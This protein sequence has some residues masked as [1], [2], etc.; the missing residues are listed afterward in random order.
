MEDPM[1]RGLIWTLLCTLLGGFAHADGPPPLIRESTGPAR[2]VSY[3]EFVSVREYA[4]LGDAISHERFL[5]IPPGTWIVDNPIVLSRDEPLY[6][7]GGDRSNTRIV[8]SDPT[9]PLFELERAPLV[10]IAGVQLEPV[11]REAPTDA[12]LIVAYNDAPT[13]LEIVD[14]RLTVGAIELLGPG[15][16]RLQNT[17]IRPRGLVTNPILLDH[18]DGRLTVLGGDISNQNKEPRVETQSAFHIRVRRGRVRIYGLSTE[19][20]IGPADFRIDS[21]SAHGPH[22]LTAVRSEGNN[23]ANS[24]AYRSTMVSVPSSSERIDLVIKSSIGAWGALGYGNGRLVEYGAAGRVWLLGNNVRTGAK[25]LVEGTGSE[26]TLV[27]IGNFAFSNQGILPVPGASRIRGG[28][29]Y[30]HMLR[31]LSRLEPADQDGKRRVKRDKPSYRFVAAEPRLPTGVPALPDDE[32]PAPL[33]RPVLRRPLDG[34]LSAADFGA[35][36][37]GLHDDTAALQALLDAQCGP[38]GSLVFIPQGRYRITRALHYNTAYS[39]KHGTGGWIVGAG[40]NKT[41][42]ERSPETPG[43][44]FVTRSMSGVTIQGLTFRTTAW[45]ADEP[46]AIKVPAFSLGGSPGNLPATHFVSFDDVRF[47]GGKYGLGVRLIHSGGNGE[48]NLIINSEFRN[49]YIGLG[50][51][52]FNVLNNTVYASNFIDNEIAIGHGEEGNRGG[53]WSV[54]GST[55]RGSHT[56]FSFQG[57]ASGA[58]YFGGLDAEARAVATRRVTGGSFPLVFDRSKLRGRN[59]G[60]LAFEVSQSGGPI[61]LHSRVNRLEMKLSGQK[62]SLYAIRIGGEVDGWERAQ[63]VGHHVR[64]Y[65]IEE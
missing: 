35:H 45:R 3:D 37:S 9:R 54:F 33:T 6:L 43:S 44:V 63:S 34:M 38:G 55:I 52:G 58:W 32:I 2:P 20:A 65:D 22:V 12:T 17:L 64:L 25:A 24:G 21:A 29:L 36:G 16:F 57:G 8:G 10:Q 18:P 41:F 31:E 62:H 53:I 47:D 46:L 50:I 40:K 56:L 5:W 13:I 39:C 14:A 61:F 4:S 19:A 11:A 30:Y 60:P 28:N 48:G 59:G 27:A 1:L 49:A 23:G 7:H 26:S 15:E 42:I 51:G